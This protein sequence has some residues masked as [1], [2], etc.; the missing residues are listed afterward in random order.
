MSDEIKVPE[1]FE[2]IGEFTPLDSP[3]TTPEPIQ[4]DTVTLTGNVGTVQARLVEI[5]NGGIGALKGDAVTATLTNGGIGAMA[6]NRVDVHITQGGIG[7]MAAREVT[8]SEGTPISV[9][10]ALT[11]KGNPKVLFDLRAG[12]LAGVVAG[13]VFGLVDF[14]LRRTVKPVRH[15]KS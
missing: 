9:M 4:A 5:K 6:A 13:G 8:V 10:A 2:H 11:V 14:V 15:H 7:A 1:A 12:V 3:A